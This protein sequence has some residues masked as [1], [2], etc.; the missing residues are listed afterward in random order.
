MSEE[1]NSAEESPELE[2]QD[3]TT[4]HARIACYCDCEVKGHRQAWFS[5]SFSTAS[6]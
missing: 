2:T 5:S 4:K 1:T 6:R 3:V